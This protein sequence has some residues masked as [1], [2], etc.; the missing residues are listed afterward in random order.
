MV[1]TSRAGQS[2]FINCSRASFVDIGHRDREPDED[3]GAIARLAEQMLDAPVDHLFAEGDEGCEQVLQVHHQRAA[4]LERHHVGAE[5]GLQ[6]REA[7]E[8]VEHHV[9]YRIAP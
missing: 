1:S 4:A 6:R 3:M 8:L 9:R 2:R 5:R 7:V